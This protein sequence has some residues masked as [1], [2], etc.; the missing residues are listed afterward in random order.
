MVS[1][2]DVIIPILER[3]N[4]VLKASGLHWELG[5]QPGSTEKRTPE[6]PFSWHFNSNSP[7]NVV[8][9]LAFMSL[10]SSSGR[11]GSVHNSLVARPGQGHRSVHL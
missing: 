6:V 10:N 7:I 4:E 8:F 5:W 11:C 1:P 3:G 9:V 2:V